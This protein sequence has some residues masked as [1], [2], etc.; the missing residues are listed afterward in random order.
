MNTLHSLSRLP[1]VILLVLMHLAWAKTIFS[2]EVIGKQP[3][4]VIIYTD[5]HNLRTLGC[6]REHLND[7][8][9]HVWGPGVKV[10]TP[11]IDSIAKGGALFTNFY[12]V[13]P[14]CT[15]SRATFMSGTYTTTNS[16]FANDQA[17]NKD[18]VTFAKILKEQLNYYTGY[19]GKVRW[20]HNVPFN[21][22]TF[23]P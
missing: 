10:D 9:A 23:L 17:M 15:P 12:T 3:N 7:A 2:Q 19:I 4:I 20:L 6:Y 18:T 1:R 8:Q 5:E 22:C 11:N 16:A 14:Q 13:S 21:M